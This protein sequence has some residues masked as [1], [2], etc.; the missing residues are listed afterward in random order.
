M[1]R[2]G[3]IQRLIEELIEITA[4]VLR[5]RTAGDDSAALQTIK[6]AAK[7]L[8]GFDTASLIRFSDAS[9]LALLSSGGTLDAG[10]ALAAGALLDAQAQIQAAQ[11]EKD[12]AHT[13]WHKSLLLLTA[14]VRQEES[15]NTEE[16]RT[17][18]TEVHAALHGQ[19]TG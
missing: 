1:V 11:G 8:I 15:L 13:S 18:I 10:K 4:K 17:R 2:K 3:Y 9:L 19:K 7:S 16:W 14:A 5:L 6:A 12:A